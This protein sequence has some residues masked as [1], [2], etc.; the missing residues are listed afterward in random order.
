MAAATATKEQTYLPR[1]ISCTTSV[2]HI[3]RHRGRH[4]PLDNVDD[5]CWCDDDDCSYNNCWC[6]DDCCSYNNCWCDDDFC[7]LLIQQLS[8]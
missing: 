6:D 2:I 7:S 1:P 4:Q 3:C 8:V 5:C